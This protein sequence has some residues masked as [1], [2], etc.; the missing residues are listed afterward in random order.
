MNWFDHA[1]VEALGLSLLHFLWQGAII[2]LLYAASL[3]LTRTASA[4]S[5]YLVAVTTLAL[6]ALAPPITLALLLASAPAASVPAA[7]G[8]SGATDAATAFVSAPSTVPATGYAIDFVHWVVLAWVAGV[9]VLS[10]RLLIGWRFLRKLRRGADFRAASALVP[11]LR[12]LAARL[13]VGRPVA[14]AVSNGIRSPVVIGYLKPLVLLPPAVMLGLPARQVEMVLAHEL[15]H[16]RRLDHLV[17]LCQTVVET[18]LFYHP[19]VRWVSNRIRTE[20]ENACDDLAV[21]VTNDRLAYVEMLAAIEKLRYRGPKLALAVDDGQVLSRIRRLV[22]RGRPGSQ[23][24][25]AGPALL[26]TL[27][28]AALGGL[29]YVEQEAETP[30]PVT[31]AAAEPEPD[32]PKP[33]PVSDA[34]AEPEPD[35]PKPEPVTETVAEPEPD[36]P[37]PEPTQAQPIEQPTRT[38]R[39]EPAAPAGELAA[40]AEPIEAR[41]ES[42]EDAETTPASSEPPELPKMDPAEP[43]PPASRMIDPEAGQALAM[44]THPSLAAPALPQPSERAAASRQP[45]PGRIGGKLIERVEPEYP[46]RARRNDIDGSV[47]V[48]FL[49]TRSGEVRDIRVLDESPRGLSFAK[50][51]REAVSDW[52]F[53]PFREGDQPVEH[54]MRLAFEFDLADDAR[55]ECRKETGSRIP[56]CY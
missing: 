34:A 56:R 14:V 2:G 28:L 45:E 13:S 20:R 8:A 55:Q 43:L 4:H 24:G 54:R 32:Q 37:K 44:L 47:E 25:L 33:E 6:L 19:V 30:E 41:T 50:S 31:E 1:L 49:V 9:I 26:I 21:T 38:E 12:A 35:Q 23:L 22:E 53:E 11:Q 5:R 3:P 17:N 40:L 52:R 15:A 51:A 18:A 10:I 16:L 39:N 7:A 46:T 42:V 48:E 29:Q 36:Q 27:V